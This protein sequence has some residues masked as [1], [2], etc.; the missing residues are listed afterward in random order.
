[1]AAIN[2]RPCRHSIAASAIQL[3]FDLA[4]VLD[5]VEGIKLNI[6]KFA[7]GFLDPTHLDVLDDVAGFGV[8]R[9][10]AARAFPGHTLHG[11]DEGVAVGRATGLL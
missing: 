3:F 5:G 10:W 4:G 11:G 2:H 6:I 7:V 1:M 8:D 9:D